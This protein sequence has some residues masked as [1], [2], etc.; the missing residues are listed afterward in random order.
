MRSR[1]WRN[2]RRSHAHSLAVLTLLL[3]SRFAGCPIAAAQQPLYSTWESYLGGP[4]SSHYSALSQIT[5]GNVQQLEVAWTYNTGDDIAYAFNPL[6]VD[7]VMYVLAKN[8]SIVALNA[9]TGKELWTYRDPATPARQVLRGLSFW[10]SQDRKEQ[11]LLFPVGEYLEEIDARTGKLF[12]SFGQ[13][14]KVDLRTGLG[15]EP[16]SIKR[17]ASGTPG[18]VY[19]NLI[20]EGSSTGEDYGSPPGDIRAYDVRTG[21]MAWIFHVVPHPGELGYDSWPSNA[22]RYS[23][24]ADAWGEMSIDAQRGI[25]YI[26]TAAPKDEFYGADRV[27]NNLF[28]DC[29]LAL[30]ARTGKLIWYYQAVHHDIWDYDLVAAPQL[31][32]V[33]HDGKKVD[34]VAEA[35]KTG[36]LYVF[37]RATGQPLWPTTERAV[38]PSHLPGEVASATQPY[39]SGPPP[40]AR[41]KFSPDDVDPYVLT[42]AD[43]A[44]WKERLRNAINLGLFTP[45]AETDTVEIPGNRGG[46]NW[47]TSASDPAK[48]MMF[49]V[50]MDLPGILR[51]ERHHPPS[52]F[53]LPHNLPPVQEG[54]AVYQE[55]CQRCH[56]ADRQGAPPAIPSLVNAPTAFGTSVIKSVVGN[57]LGNMPAF[58]DL[59]GNLLDNL[60]EYLAHPEQAPTPVQLSETERAA[61]P[62]PPGVKD[63]PNVFYYTPYGLVPEAIKPPWST[64]TAYDLNT[65]KIKWQVPFGSAPQA[66]TVTGSSIMEPR[67]GLAVTSSGLI[68][69]ATVD[70]GR[71][72]AYDENTGQ[73]LWSVELPAASEGVP[74]IYQENGREYLVVCATSVKGTSLPRDR[75]AISQPHTKPVERS[76]IAYVLPADL[77]AAS[78]ARFPQLPRAPHA[79]PSATARPVAGKD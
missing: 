3:G 31:L 42:A 23:G 47:G 57:G 54:R 25:V 63:V 36:F 21:K 62:Y 5:P 26:P 50:S 4:E 17:I 32:T 78:N 34:A 19:E 71:L 7:K 13:Q 75:S 69:A 79:P 18:I 73:V 48:G 76:Y 72:R 41:Q 44:A 67:N 35:G 6:I 45:P 52:L 74:A 65:G 14:G 61:S 12:P 15:R 20:I 43:Q 40:F 11:R 55:F 28:S 29:L 39:P 56:G 30:N 64:I 22:W 77:A 9:D 1:I 53:A 8:N 68:F 58:T 24:G 10:K 49:V 37:D 16:A 33:M 2:G 27:G 66:P 59:T 70:E 60:I 38:P 46:A 51:M